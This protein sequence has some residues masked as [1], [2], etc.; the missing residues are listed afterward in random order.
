M[1]GVH[2]HDADGFTDGDY[3]RLKEWL[4]DRKKN[5]IVAL[6]EI[7]PGLIITTFLKERRRSSFSRRQLELALKR[8]SRLSCI[9]GTRQRIP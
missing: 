2:P 5:R 7:G 6:G 8:M 1:A 3:I 9:R 4:P